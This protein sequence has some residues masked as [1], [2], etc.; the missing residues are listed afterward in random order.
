M[1]VNLACPSCGG[2]GTE[3]DLNKW[4]CLHC[5][6]KF[7][8]VPPTSPVGQGSIQRIDRSD[9]ELDASS[10]RPATQILRSQ[11]EVDPG[12]FAEPP[13][14]ISAED[15]EAPDDSGYGRR[16]LGELAK[17]NEASKTVWFLGAMM[18]CLLAAKGIVDRNWAA[19]CA[20][21]AVGCLVMVW[22]RRSEATEINVMLKHARILQQHM[23]EKWNDF[24]AKKNEKVI[25]GHQP[26]CPFCLSEASG[27]SGFNQCARCGKPFHYENECSYR[28]K[29]K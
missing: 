26:V 5:G 23:E 20:V 14:V 10:A 7:A 9:Y 25:V 28:I 3:Y 12:A 16:T 18:F 29:L 27:A 1:I 6:S 4:A 2:Q 8:F 13:A 19:L 21:P 11:Y 22:L 24:E 15:Q 17:K